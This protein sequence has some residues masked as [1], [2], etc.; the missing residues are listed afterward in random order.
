[1]RLCQIA[2][3][4]DEKHTNYSSALTSLKEMACLVTTQGLAHRRASQTTG[5]T[6]SKMMQ[7]NAG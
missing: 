1:M 6:P 5:R 4:Q 7:L 3:R 2:Y